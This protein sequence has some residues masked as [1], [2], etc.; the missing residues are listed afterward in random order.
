MNMNLEPGVVGTYEGK[1]G[2]SGSTLTEDHTAII[3]KPSKLK[4]KLRK[5]LIKYK[6][7]ATFILGP[8][9]KAIYMYINFKFLIAY[10]IYIYIYHWGIVY[11]HKLKVHTEYFLRVINPNTRNQELCCSNTWLWKMLD[12]V[13]KKMSR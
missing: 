7:N 11:T 10:N 4:Q 2:E 8:N 9:F 3:I 1:T 12:R 6:R 5:Y 13:K